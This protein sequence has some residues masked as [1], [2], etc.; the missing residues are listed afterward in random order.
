[1]GTLYYF[2]R[3]NGEVVQIGFDNDEEFYNIM[4]QTP[5]K[6]EKIADLEHAQLIELTRGEALQLLA[7]FY[8]WLEYE[9]NEDPPKKVEITTYVKMGN[10]LEFSQAAPA[11]YAEHFD[12]EK[13][14]ITLG[15]R[16]NTDKV[17]KIILKDGT[18]ELHLCK[19]IT[20]GYRTVRMRFTVEEAQFILDKFTAEIGKDFA[21]EILEVY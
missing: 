2:A 8:Y 9:P 4:I 1:M 10:G 7:V 6:G 20:K 15:D 18:I 21:F 3:G 13:N 12:I 5:A 11:D 17:K 19:R 16:Q 14:A